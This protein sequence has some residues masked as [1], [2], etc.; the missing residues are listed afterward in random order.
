MINDLKVQ[1]A[2]LNPR[3]VNKRFKKCS[4]NIE[5]LQGEVNSQRDTYNNRLDMIMNENNKLE[6][7]LET[8]KLKLDE[9]KTKFNKFSKMKS[10]YKFKCEQQVEKANEA[11]STLKNSEKNVDKLQK[12]VDHLQYIVKE[13]RIEKIELFEGGRYK[14]EIRQVYMD[15]LSSGVSIEKCATAFIIAVEAQILSQAQAAEVMLGYDNNC[16]HL[17]ET[18]KRFT[19]YGGFQVSTEAGSSSLSHKVMPSG[20]AGSHLEATNE[21]FSELAE[22]LSEENSEKTNWR[23][24]F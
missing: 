2:N 7:D 10:Y 16:L 21:T 8:L 20:D 1:I 17:D 11:K 6:N 14:A 24:T 18:K 9:Q 12:Q 4:K 22:P 19:E 15:L 13:N 5:K 3:N 23:Q